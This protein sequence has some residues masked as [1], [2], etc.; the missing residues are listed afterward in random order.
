MSYLNTKEHKDWS[1]AVRQRD[2]VCIVCQDN[3]H[4][5]AHHLIPK[6]FPKTRSDINNGVTLC[7]RHHMRFGYKLS[8]HSHGAMLFFI[9]LLRNRPDIIKWVEEHWDGVR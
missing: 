5:T 9:W 1:N 2:K 6:E 3:S 8:P 4:L 7:S